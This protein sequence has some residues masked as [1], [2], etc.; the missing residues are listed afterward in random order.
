MAIVVQGLNT[1]YKGGKEKKNQ[2]AGIYAKQGIYLPGNFPFKKKKK[3]NAEPNHT[4]KLFYFNSLILT[5][6]SSL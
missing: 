3:T 4:S 5:F 1:E 2:N 6:F